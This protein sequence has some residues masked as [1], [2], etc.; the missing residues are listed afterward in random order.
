[1]DVIRRIE[2]LRIEKGWTKYKL[3][4]ES[5]LTYSTLSSMYARETPPK[6]DILQMICEGFGITLSQ[7]FLDNEDIEVVTPDEKELI[8]RYRRLSDEKKKAV[9]ILIDK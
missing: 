5:L 3:A 4:E 6:L 2:E 8:C 7:F 1:M 9:N